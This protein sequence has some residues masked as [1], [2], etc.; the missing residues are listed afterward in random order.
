MK[1]IEMTQGSLWKNIL[2]FSVPLMLTQV[3]EVLF[4][5]SDV[6]V[7]GKFASYQA[8]G[9]VGSTTMLVTLFTGFLIGLGAGVNVAVARA[10]GSGNDRETEQTVHSSFVICTAMGLAVGLVCWIF[11]RPM[12]VALNTKDEL[13]EG[14]VLYLRLYALGLPANALYNC[15][16]GIMSAAGDTKR[17]LIYLSIAGALNVALNLFF[18]IG[19]HMAADGVALASS[20]AQWVSAGLIVI[21]LLRSTDSCRLEVRKLRIHR[22]VS[23][24]I[25]FI[26]VPSGMQ[27]AIFAFANLFVQMGINSFDAVTVSGSAAAANADTLMFNMM[28]AFYTACA[29]F[30]SRNWGAGNTGRILK[31]FYI[32]MLYASLTGAF[33][34]GLLVIFG[35]QFLGLFANEPEVIEAGM[36]RLRIMGCSFF[37]APFM[38]ASIAASRGIGRSIV[39]T[40]IVIMGSCVFR[41]I[42]VY[43][44]FAYF[45]TIPSLYLLYVFSWTITGTVEYIYFRRSYKK[46]LTEG[47]PPAVPSAQN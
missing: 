24:R 29:S 33:F 40:V 13:L 4:N 28:A 35:R 14:A 42:W 10:L 43:T 46:C 47:A 32:S 37:V 15:G 34:G 12:L 18:V 38:D 6:A 27:N 45:H 9:S 23:K 5:L 3:L 22:A 17:P 25:L 16:N 2:L 7:V 1:K 8:L 26:G 21:H 20:I 44:V 39:P 11:A 19:L 41:V 36:Q 31:S 30:V